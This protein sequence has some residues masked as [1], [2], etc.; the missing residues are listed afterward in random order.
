MYV[1]RQSSSMSRISIGSQ[2]DVMT[3]HCHPS[4]TSWRHMAMTLKRYAPSN[5]RKLVYTTSIDNVSTRT[6]GKHFH[7]IIIICISNTGLHRLASIYRIRNNMNNR[8]VYRAT[9]GS[10]SYVGK[11]L[12]NIMFVMFLSRDETTQHEVLTHCLL[13]TLLHRNHTMFVEHKFI[14]RLP[15]YITYLL[16]SVLGLGLLSRHL[17]ITPWNFL[18]S[19]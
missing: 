4:E 19:I 2:N 12:Y 11:K 5:P 1:K 8:W 14:L 18:S 3:E 15:E 17:Y 9:W 7:I 16:T 6:L 13:H 10:A